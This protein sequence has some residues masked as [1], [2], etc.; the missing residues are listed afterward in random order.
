MT[1]ILHDGQHAYR[2]PDRAGRRFGWFGVDGSLAITPRAVARL[3]AMMPAPPACID[4]DIRAPFVPR[5]PDTTL[6]WRTR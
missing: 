5:T 2:E 3:T 6:L 1:E 4:W